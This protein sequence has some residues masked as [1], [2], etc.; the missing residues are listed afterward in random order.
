MRRHG[1]DIHGAAKLVFAFNH[2]AW[3]HKVEGD[4]AP[5]DIIKRM[6]ENLFPDM[7]SDIEVLGPEPDLVFENED[8]LSYGI[9]TKYIKIVFCLGASSA[10]VI[11]LNGHPQW[12]RWARKRQRFQ[13][14]AAH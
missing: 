4:R 9:T 11:A 10:Y 8:S 7:A 14:R 3:S 13:G 2:E 5:M 12:H 6:I 1:G